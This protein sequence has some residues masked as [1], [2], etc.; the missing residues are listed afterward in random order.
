MKPKAYRYAT[1]VWHADPHVIVRVP[2][3]DKPRKLATAT[4]AI[5]RAHGVRRA[6]FVAWDVITDSPPTDYDRRVCKDQIWDRLDA[7]FTCDGAFFPRHFLYDLRDGEFHLVRKPI[8]TG[9]EPTK[10][11]NE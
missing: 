8:E 6:D 7:A 11:M 2:A 3:Q 1:V 9:A 4:N 5:M 10:D